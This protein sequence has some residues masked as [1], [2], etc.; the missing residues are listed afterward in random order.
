MGQQV[1]Q[2]WQAR[3]D[4]RAMTLSVFR[5]GAAARNLSVVLRSDGCAQN[6]LHFLGCEIERSVARVVST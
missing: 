6:Y 5:A 2:Q 1:R 3:T 4:R